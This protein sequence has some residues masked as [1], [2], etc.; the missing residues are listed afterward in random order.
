[1]GKPIP[2][3][4]QARRTHT[5]AVGEGLDP[6]VASI[7]PAGRGNTSSILAEKPILGAFQGGRGMV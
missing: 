3:N 2:Y 7:A 1:M 5:N 4:E 6:P